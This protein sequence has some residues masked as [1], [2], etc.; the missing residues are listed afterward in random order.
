MVYQREVV[1]SLPAYVQGKSIP[2][3][4]KLSSNENP[5][6]P[7]ASVLE[8][9]RE[10]AGSFNLYPDMSARELVERIA[11]HLDV[12]PSEVAVGAGSVE[13]AAQLIHACAGEGDEVMFA[14]R[15]FEAYP[16]LTRVAGATPVPVPL[17]ADD[18]HD[19]DAM[20]AAI[21]DRTRLILVCTP[22]NP[23]GAVVTRHEM[24]AFLDRVPSGI[25]VVIDEAYTHFDDDPESASG[26]EFFR[27]YD[28]VAVL[29]TFSKA[30]GLAGLRVGYA[31]A[32]EEVAANLRRVAVPFGVSALAQTAAVASLDAEEELQ[33]RIDLI[34][35]ERVRLLAALRQEG[36]EVFD[37]MGNFIWLRTGENT[38][39]IDQALRD[40]GIVARAFPGDGIRVTIGTPD[41]ND[42]FI[43]A[44]LSAVRPNELS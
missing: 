18:R 1:A 10:Q 20:L 30:Y 23:T 37:S 7:L 33:D 17:T 40:R 16:I 12:K 2:S 3:A 28:N 14:W 22:N 41:M 39:A 44:I 9:V 34:R 13:V 24:Q 11:R 6:P 43:A 36:M 19:L 25:L 35:S 21:T 4:V 29:H 27:S 5:Y 8:V 26:L 42:S 15:S 31:V 38:V 32:H